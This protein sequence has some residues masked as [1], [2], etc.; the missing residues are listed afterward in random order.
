MTE[1]ISVAEHRNGVLRDITFEMLSKGRELARE[2]G[3]ELKALILGQHVDGLA[4]EL[5]EKADEV[6]V[7]ESEALS[8]FNA[9]AYQQVL[10]HYMGE[11]NPI[12]T[13]IGHTSYGVD[14]APAL[15]VETGAPIATDCIDV[16][17]RDGVVNVVRQVYGGKLNLKASLQKGPMYM[18]TIRPSTFE[19]DGSEGKEGEIVHMEIPRTLNLEDKRFIE[20]VEPPLEGVDISDADI[21]VSIGRGIKDDK[22]ITLAKEL[23]ETLKGE[24][25]CSRPIVDKGWLPKN[26]QVGSSGKTVKPKLYIAAGISGSF[27]HVMGMKNSDAII[28]INRDPN[29]P[30]FRIADYGIV[31]DMFKIIPALTRKTRESKRPS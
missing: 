11:N 1:I 7:F 12:L 8:E 2:I 19:P 23:A 29:A 26:R 17:F 20:Y 13:L 9:E 28:A 6:L 3:V 24:M 18:V 15:A 16:T 25:G 27:Q 31:D 30:I 5:R 4:E 21:I 10:S 22:N 14:L